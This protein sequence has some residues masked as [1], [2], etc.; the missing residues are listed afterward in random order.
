LNNKVL[1][2]GDGRLGIEM[3]NQTNWD[4]ISR[5]KN[6]DID[7]LNPKSYIKNSN[8]DIIIN[9]IAY[10][11]TIDDNKQKHW[12]IN[13][14]F[15]IDLVEECN[16]YGKKLV[17][18]SSDYI[19]SNSN[20]NANENDI[21]I[22]MPTWYTYTKLLSDAYVEAKSDNFLTIRTSFKLRP[23]IHDSAWLDLKG[24]FDYVDKIVEKIIFLIKNKAD[25]IFNVGTEIK[26]IFDLAKQSKDNVLPTTIKNNPNHM[27]PTDVTMDLS[28][29]SKFLNNV[30]N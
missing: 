24:N 17:H 21:P 6:P 4:I 3:H 25:G 7:F 11:N 26:S 16:R 9:C 28:K 15:V 5:K 23:W 12:D 2:L 22:H 29:Y 1:I 18:I 8:H 20:E 13:Y 19:Y 30:N 10:T 27:R 14:K